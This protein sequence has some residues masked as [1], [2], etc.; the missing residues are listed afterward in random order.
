MRI[1]LSF[2]LMVI[3]RSRHACETKVMIKILASISVFSAAGFCLLAE[4]GLAEEEKP[5]QAE[6]ERLASLPLQERLKRAQATAEGKALAAWWSFLTRPMGPYGRCS[7]WRRYSELEEGKKEA[8]QDWK[9]LSPSKLESYQTMLLKDLANAQLEVVG[10]LCVKGFLNANEAAAMR[11]RLEEMLWAVDQFQHFGICGLFSS[12]EVRQRYQSAERLL[13][14]YLRDAG[15]Q[16]AVYR[17]EDKTVNAREAYLDCLEGVGREVFVALE[18]LP[19]MTEETLAIKGLASELCGEK[20]LKRM[21]A[22]LSG[23]EYLTNFN[24]RREYCAKGICVLGGKEEIPLMRKLLAE[25]LTVGVEEG[26]FPQ[27]KA[28][29]EPAK[30]LPKMCRRSR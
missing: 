19:R 24:S 4:N 1:M 16:M 7:W 12:A 14:C 26:Y 18:R 20:A 9:I 13:R 25:D 22:M 29:E 3:T 2:D 8:P 27:R 10:E 11:D 5:A 6:K 23:P 21:V 30:D 28:G 17:K 15:D